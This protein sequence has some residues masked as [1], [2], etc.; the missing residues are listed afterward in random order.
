MPTKFEASSLELGGARKRDQLSCHRPTQ[1]AG[2]LVA[3][4]LHPGNVLRRERARPIRAD[5]DNR[6]RLHHR[7]H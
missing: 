1:R 4:A 2:S 6:G 5:N 3:E 7:K